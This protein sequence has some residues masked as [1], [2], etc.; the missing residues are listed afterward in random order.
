VRRAAA[1][2]PTPREARAFFRGL[3]RRFALLAALYVVLPPAADFV[4]GL[5][6]ARADCRVVQVVDGDTVDFRCPERGLVRVRL[7]GF[8]APELFSPGCVSEAGA[9][10][11]AQWYLRRALWGADRIE[12][13]FGRDDRYGRA[14]A[15]ARIDGEDL[16]ERM[17]AAG[18]GRAYAGGRR[19]GWCGEA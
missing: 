18:H 3:A 15:G 19:G 1:A 7:D 12:L 8:D 17:I 6:P 14:V 16:A 11:A 10:V 13:R 5:R 2:N 4:A 9:A